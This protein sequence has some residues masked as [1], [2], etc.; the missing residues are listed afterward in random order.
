MPITTGL[1]HVATLTTDL[2]R[3]VAF[4]QNAFDAQVVFEIPHRGAIDH[5]GLAADSLATPPDAPRAPRRRRCPGGGSHPTTRTGL[6][7]VL[8]RSRRHGA[9]SLRSE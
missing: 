7:A 1:N 5:Y 2:A 8:P 3:I 9:R 4:Y 6:V